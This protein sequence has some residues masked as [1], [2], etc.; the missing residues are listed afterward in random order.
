MP[1][2]QAT[3]GQHC[4]S[5]PLKIVIKIELVN[6]GPRPRPKRRDGYPMPGII[7]CHVEQ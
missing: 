3:W 2:K 6:N 1:Q 7:F 4:F 5:L